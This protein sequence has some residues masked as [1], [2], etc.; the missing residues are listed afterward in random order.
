MKISKKQFLVV[1]GVLSVAMLGGIAN[2]D[3]IYS[4][5][6]AALP[7]NLPSLGYE[8]TSTTEFGDH[9][10][11]AGSARKLN[12]VTITMSDWAMAST[13]GSS[14]A[15]YNHDLTFN[16]YNYIGDTVAGSLIGTTTMNAFVPWRP[17]ND[18][19][20]NCTDGT[21]WYSTSEGT[22]Y[23]GLAFNVTFDFSSL[24][25]IL[26]NDIVFGLSYNTTNYGVSPTG[27]SG[28]YDSLNYA[29]VS[30]SPSVGTDVNPDG[31]FW[32]TT[33]PGGTAGVFGQNTGWAGYVPA[34]S[35]DASVPEPTT[36]ALAGLALFGVA[37][38]RRRVR[39]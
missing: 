26:P 13:Y 22:C 34:A 18:I 21:S 14:A 9:I 10:Q 7:G 1:A 38:T 28:P 17:E 31:V 35:F 39:R 32:N 11:F 6:P 36:L 27:V 19:S 8:A 2:A 3:V 20:G 4:N 30:S 33:Y 5:L 12:L 29:L 24:G 16:I 25:L 23:H 15:G 37:A